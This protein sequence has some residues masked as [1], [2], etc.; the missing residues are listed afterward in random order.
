MLSIV[1]VKAI[2]ERLGLVVGVHRI[3][4]NVEVSEGHAQGASYGEHADVV[5]GKLNGLA[6]ADQ[7][8]LLSSPSSARSSCNGATAGGVGGGADEVGTGGVSQPFRTASASTASA[9]NGLLVAYGGPNSATI[10]SRSVIRTVSPDAA[11]R[12]YSLSLLFRTFMPTDLMKR[13]VTPRCYLVKVVT[14]GEGGDGGHSRYP[15]YPVDWPAPVPRHACAASPISWAACPRNTSVVPAPGSRVNARINEVFARLESWHLILRSAQK[16]SSVQRYLFATG[17]LRALRESA[18]PAIS[19]VHTIAPAARTPL[20]AIIENQAAIELA[21]GGQPL[22]GWKRSPAGSYGTRYSQLSGAEL[23]GLGKCLYM[24]R[25]GVVEYVGHQRGNFGL[26]ANRW[27]LSGRAPDE[28][29]ALQGGQGR[30]AP[31]PSPRSHRGLVRGRG[32]RA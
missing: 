11:T 13:T 31:A 32:R 5:A 3:L 28:A 9:S 4:R 16:G 15:G 8:A 29:Q 18:V 24:R 22:A 25:C 21:R 20:G 10:R 7:R 1:L 14:G 23:S 6:S 19:A 2:L 17:V 27:K 30:S 26:V 12:T